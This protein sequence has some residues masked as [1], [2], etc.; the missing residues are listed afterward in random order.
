M[1]N[2][3]FLVDDQYKYP[4]HTT[5]SF[6]INL[7]LSVNEMN[8]IEDFLKKNEI[9]VIMIDNRKI[10]KVMSKDLLKFDICIPNEQR[11]RD[12]DKVTEIVTYQLSQ[13]KN[14]GNCNIM[15]VI[16]IHCCQD[17]RQLY[18]V[19]GQH[20][21]E[22]IRRI[23]ET[24]N[25]AIIIEI[26]YVSD[27]C[28]L[29]NNYNIINKNTSLPEFPDTIDKNLP[30][31]V[32]KYFKASFPNIWSKSSRARRPQIY[33]NYFQEALGIL[34]NELSITDKEH[35]INL[36]IERNNT[37]SRWSVENYPEHKSISQTMMNKCEDNGIYLGLY[38]H[39]SDD[40]RYGWVRDIIK[41]YTGKDMKQDKVVIRKKQIPKTLKNV[42]WDKNIG[43]NKRSALCICCVHNEIKIENFHAGH[44]ISE[45]EGGKVDENNLLPICSS[46]N[47]SMAT[48]N[49]SCFVKSN[50]PNN[51][52]NF[53]I[54]NYKSSNKLFG[55]L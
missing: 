23:N 51:H 39:V 19:D 12:D 1:K 2:Y 15:G 7:A 31:D 22:A 43:K 21:Y 41:H 40:F 29:K 36:I 30:E 37:L 34:A 17:T 48:M 4:S 53:G 42:I 50:F 33:F 28:E 35:L 10:C 9:E 32:A 45:K 46:C 54:R 44:I 26:V 8:Q 18:L 24:N 55:F 16:N 14:K 49:M 27:I 13:I 5:L 47:A 6:F 3:K 11:I 52:L 38:K 25:I 20:R